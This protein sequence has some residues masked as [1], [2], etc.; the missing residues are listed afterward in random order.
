M[1]K[2]EFAL[3]LKIADASIRGCREKLRNAE[4]EKQELLAIYCAESPIKEGDKVTWT[5]KRR[6]SKYELQK[7]IY[8]VS[9]VRVN[10]YN[11]N[12]YSYILYPMKK[13]GTM[14]KTGR[15]FADLNEGSL[16]LTTKE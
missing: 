8:I 14:S 13:D 16:A 2:N 15:K 9:G 5:P 1:E 3:R 10:G 6:V 11:G 12:E 4:K 7:G